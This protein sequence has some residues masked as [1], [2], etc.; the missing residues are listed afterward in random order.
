MAGS[1]VFVGAMSVTTVVESDNAA[2]DDPTP[3]IAITDTLMKNPTS[4]SV[5]TYVGFI[6]VEISTYV[7]V[8]VSE[9]FHW[10]AYEVGEPD[11][12][13][14]DE[15]KV[16]PVRAVPVITAAVVIDGA[17]GIE[18]RTMTIPDP[19]RPPVPLFAPPPP[20]PVLATPF[21]A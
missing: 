11:Q 1:A 8:E 7:P 12:V 16:S 20:L 18:K 9:R 6:S 13:P 2:L 4:N 19:P 14:V 21:V 15:V 17:A 5:T 10:Y 3:F